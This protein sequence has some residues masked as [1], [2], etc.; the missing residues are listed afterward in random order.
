MAL[1]TIVI[2]PKTDLLLVE[3][4]VAA[5][6][7]HLRAQLLNGDLTADD[8]L[9]KLSEQ[10]WDVVWFAAHGDEKGIHVSNGEVLS[11]ALLTSFIRTAGAS[12]VVFNTCS[13]YQVAQ[14][15]YN[16]LLI[17]LVCTIRP[18]PD[19]DA[20]FTG[21]SFA[22]HLGRGKSPH[23]AYLAAKMGGNIDYIFMN[24]RERTLPPVAASSGEIAVLSE[25]VRRLVRLVDGD[26][27]EQEPGLRKMV[28][29][30]ATELA[31]LRVEV[32]FL[33]FGMW[34]MA[35]SSVFIAAILVA[36][37]LTGGGP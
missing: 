37:L 16:E 20:F 10:T 34:V 35:G 28:K 11:S 32:R 25:E 30:Q 24:K 33:K 2:A 4:E 36:V 6:V 3:A 9:N 26:T 31:S 5:V 15:I 27:R 1:R 18:I 19:K 21:K 17:D 13:S 12:L 22:I 8:V 23:E 14:L 7:N 29:D